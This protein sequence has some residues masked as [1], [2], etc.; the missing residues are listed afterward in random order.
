MASATMATLDLKKDFHDIRKLHPPNGF[1]EQFS[2]KVLKET[3]YFILSQSYPNNV[4][5]HQRYVST[6]MT[7]AHK[8]SNFSIWNACIVILN[9]DA[10]NMKLNTDVFGFMLRLYSIYTNKIESLNNN[11]DKRR[12]NIYLPIPFPSRSPPVPGPF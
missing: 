5:L 1:T 2:P 3:V 10:N 9:I 4:N 8:E 6:V 11:I 7:K 12:F